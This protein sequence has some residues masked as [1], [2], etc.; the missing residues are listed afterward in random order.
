MQQQQWPQSGAAHLR[1]CTLSLQVVVLQSGSAKALSK[2]RV[3]RLV[4]GASAGTSAHTHKGKMTPAAGGEL[5]TAS[6]TARLGKHADAARVHHTLEAAAG[7]LP[8]AC[9]R[10]PA[11]CCQACRHPP[12]RLQ[13]ERS[14][15]SR[16]TS[17]VS[18]SLQAGRQAGRERRGQ[19]GRGNGE[20]VRK[21]GK[22]Q[23]AE[24]GRSWLSPQL[25]PLLV[26]WARI[27]VHDSRP[28]FSLP[29]PEYSL[30]EGEIVKV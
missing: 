17:L 26:S 30:Q 15:S 18:T 7:L 5:L 2:D 24:V 16:L 6:G 25:W 14:S 29:P 20:V 8:A 4:R 12:D 1:H 11:A 13:E 23:A 21:G 9:R 28:P 27:P 19:R 3:V 10:L 22:G